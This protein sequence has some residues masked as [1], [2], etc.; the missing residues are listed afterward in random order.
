MRPRRN[1]GFLDPA[2]PSRAGVG[3]GA[4]LGG[5]AAA[6]ISAGL[7]YW[8]GSAGDPTLKRFHHVAPPP[9]YAPSDADAGQV[10]HAY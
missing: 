8:I 2:P 5:I 6:G 1:P 10:A 9:V 4:A 7:V 3:I